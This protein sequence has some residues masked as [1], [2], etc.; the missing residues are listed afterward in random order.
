M[1]GYLEREHIPASS[2]RRARGERRIATPQVHE[3]QMLYQ[4]PDTPPVIDFAADAEIVR[5]AVEGERLSLLKSGACGC[6]QDQAASSPR[7]CQ[8]AC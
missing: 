7:T 8:Q 2:G 3:P 1:D 6:S 4:E 5:T